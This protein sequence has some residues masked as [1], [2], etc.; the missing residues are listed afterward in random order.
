MEFRLIKVASTLVNAESALTT[1]ARTMVDLIKWVR[2]N[3][4]HCYQDL[5]AHAYKYKKHK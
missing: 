3:E 1:R 5:M 2:I 4:R